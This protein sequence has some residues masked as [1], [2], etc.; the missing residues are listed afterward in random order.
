MTFT[1]NRVFLHCGIATFTEVQDLLQV[2]LPPLEAA[3]SLDHYLI[4]LWESFQAITTLK[5][6]FH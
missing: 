2:L 5:N 3:N 6:V 4:C 1:Y